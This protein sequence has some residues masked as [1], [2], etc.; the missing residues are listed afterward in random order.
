MISHHAAK[1][2][3][4]KHCASGD[5]M[6]LVCH[7]ISQHHIT[8]ESFHFSGRSTSKITILP[9]LVATDNG[10]GD[11]M[12]LVCHVILLD[13]SIRGSFDVIARNLLR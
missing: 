4:H 9:I 10:I 5:I 6:S 12:V 2:Y 1:C 3:G 11:I 13:R 8:Q 7:A